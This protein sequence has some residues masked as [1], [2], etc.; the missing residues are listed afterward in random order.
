MI[1]VLLSGLLLIG[2]GLVGG[3]STRIRKHRRLLVIVGA[4]LVLA[5]AIPRMAR[6]FSEA[7]RVGS[8]IRESQGR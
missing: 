1:S 5:W 7:Y 4:A 3:S 6:G 8:E 2:L